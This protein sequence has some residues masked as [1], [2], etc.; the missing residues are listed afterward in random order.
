MG[1]RVLRFR[2][3]SLGVGVPCGSVLVSVVPYRLVERHVVKR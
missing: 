2:V 1:F 3:Q